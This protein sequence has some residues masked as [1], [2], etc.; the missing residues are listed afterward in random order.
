MPTVLS[1][2]LSLT[3]K[4]QFFNDLV[5]KLKKGDGTKK[6]KILSTIRFKINLGYLPGKHIKT[7]SLN[8]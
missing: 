8:F 4:T 5:C 2:K 7:Q 3:D 6:P 1:K